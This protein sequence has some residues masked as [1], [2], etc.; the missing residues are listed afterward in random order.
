MIKIE[1]YKRGKGVLKTFPSL[2]DSSE[3]KA[4][5]KNYCESNNIEVVAI[6]TC[7]NS[8]WNYLSDGTEIDYSIEYSRKR[9]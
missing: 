5:I 6:E 4:F 9:E 7:D 1:L 2:S 3:A 8:Y